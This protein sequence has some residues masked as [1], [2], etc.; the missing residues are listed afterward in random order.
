MPVRVPTYGDRH[1]HKV[2]LLDEPDTLLSQTAASERSMGG[3]RGGQ[4]VKKSGGAGSSKGAG[5]KKGGQ[6]VKRSE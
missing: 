6:V 3:N 5:S 4:T 1:P 2:Q